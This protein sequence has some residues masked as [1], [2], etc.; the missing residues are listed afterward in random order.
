[1][2]SVSIQTKNLLSWRIRTRQLPQNLRLVAVYRIL[3]APN[4]TMDTRASLSSAAGRQRCQTP[5]L[6]FQRTTEML[7]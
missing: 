6:L 3:I 7:Y 5:S 1:M 4:W 2:T